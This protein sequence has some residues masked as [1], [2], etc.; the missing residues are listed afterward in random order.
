MTATNKVM[1]PMANALADV[2]KEKGVKLI[3]GSA[4][5]V[6]K[7]ILFLCI[8]HPA[9]PYFKRCYKKLIAMD[10]GYKTLRPHFFW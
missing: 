7:A 1:M 10:N 4:T 8:W 5:T 2:A 3:L 6:G 9:S